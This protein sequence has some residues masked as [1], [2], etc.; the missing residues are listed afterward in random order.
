MQVLEGLVQRTQRA[1][2][3]N[4]KA[5]GADAEVMEGF[6]RSTGRFCGAQWEKIN[7]F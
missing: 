7:K 3:A 5:V 6:I 4:A 2:E 1:V